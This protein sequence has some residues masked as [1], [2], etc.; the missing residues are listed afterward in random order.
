M[1]RPIEKTRAE[2]GQA[3]V[4]IVL[5]IVGIVGFAALA[6]DGGMVY[7]ERRRAQN[8]ADSAVYAAALAA[9]QKKTDTEGANNAYKQATLNGFTTGSG[10]TVQVN[11]P[12]VAPSRY[13]GNTNY[14][15]VVISAEVQPI[16]SHF[17]FS[18]VLRNTVEA[19][20]RA[21]PARPVSPGNAL[22]AVGEGNLC[23]GIWFTGSGTT[24]ITGANILANSTADAS[25]CQSGVRDGAG[26]VT[27][28]GGQVRVGGQFDGDERD[29]NHD[30][31]PDDIVTSPTCTVA[32][33]VT[34][35]VLPP[36]QLPNCSGFA[37]NKRAFSPTLNTTTH[38]YEVTPGWY[39]GGVDWNGHDA[40]HFKP[41]LYCIEGG[42][43]FNG[44]D[45]RSI[46]DGSTPEGVMFYV[47]SGG[48]DFGGN[49]QI[50][51][52]R[53]DSLYDF[54]TPAY[55]WGGMFLYMPETNHSEISL[56]GGGNSTYTGTIYAP[57]PSDSGGQKCTIGGNAGNVGLLSQVICYSIKV[58]GTGDV[59]INY[60]P[61]KVHNPPPT[62]ELTQ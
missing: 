61:T 17:I 58:H 54:A 39:V 50:N 14:Y 3:L 10:T 46:A 43:P 60:D 25:N 16:F 18:G 32:E 53:P 22:H 23:K 11:H 42:I 37:T 44:G 27:V 20:A 48:V 26:Q 29:A 35:E 34:P 9:A 31:C 1:K 55:Q 57:G 52:N 56:A 45:I 41:G 38:A 7:A 40:L 36:L 21:V 12:P 8:A 5:A 28:T 62:V 19:V 33:H 13:A 59:V 30:G 49:G 51:L 2:K 24:T 15:Q 4:I 47:I 6:I